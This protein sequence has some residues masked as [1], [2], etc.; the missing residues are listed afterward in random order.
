MGAV[1]TVLIRDNQFQSLPQQ[2]YAQIQLI[3]RQNP[4]R[5]RSRVVS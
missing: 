5:L 1:S 3:K 4:V 2:T